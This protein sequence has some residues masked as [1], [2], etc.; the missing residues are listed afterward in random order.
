[1]QLEE[2]VT[3]CSSYGDRTFSYQGPT[4]WNK[5]PEEVRC[6]RINTGKIQKIFKNSH[7][8]IGIWLAFNVLVVKLCFILF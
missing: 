4:Q 1:M 7:V 2:P 6:C 5:L 3:K 8:E